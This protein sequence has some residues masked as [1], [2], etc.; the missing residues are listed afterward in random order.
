MLEVIHNTV[1]FNRDAVRQPKMPT[2]II[3]ESE[4]KSHNP[5]SRNIYV[6]VEPEIINPVQNELIARSQEYDFILTHNTNVLNR[7]KNAHFYIF[8]SSWIPENEYMAINT[9][10]KKF[11]LTSITGGK[12]WAPGHRFRQDVYYEQLSITSIPTRFFTSHHT[13]DLP[14]I[15]NNPILYDRKIELFKDSQFSLVI[16]N[17]KQ[18]NY[19]TEKI[20]D[21]VITKT[22]PVYWGCPNISDFFDTTGWIIIETPSVDE[23]LE[24]LEVLNEDYYMKYMHIVKKNFETVKKYIDVTENINRALCT[25]PDY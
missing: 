11:M 4:E 18:I 12:R 2:A 15:A 8:G 7:C 20:C 3:F 13:N 22:I 6:Q 5:G 25:I 21:C 24:K 19:F 17:S 14:V 9:K 10:D 23:L 1:G 16:E